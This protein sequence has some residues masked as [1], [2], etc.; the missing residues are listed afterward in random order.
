MH[1]LQGICCNVVVDRMLC[2]YSNTLN[3][4]FGG[5][6]DV[7]IS[8]VNFRKMLAIFYKIDRERDTH[9]RTHARKHTH[10][11]T[12]T[13]RE[14]E[15][16]RELKRDRD[17]ERGT[18]LVISLLAVGVL[19][20]L[21]IRYL[22]ALVTCLRAFYCNSIIQNLTAQQNVVIII[23]NSLLLCNKIYYETSGV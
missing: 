8:R 15:R 21:R 12:H 11:R 19:E 9:V 5:H 16:E 22:R 4:I 10:A 20:Y 3:D 23:K 14:R 2:R 17:R 18:E 13:P 1:M 6:K 7:N